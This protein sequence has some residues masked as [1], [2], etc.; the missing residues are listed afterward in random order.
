MVAAGMGR[1][2]KRP[3]RTDRESVKDSLMHEA[4]LARFTQHADLRVILLKIGAA[5][6]PVAGDE[7]RNT[8]IGPIRSPGV[9]TDAG[10]AVLE[11]DLELVP[12]RL[13]LPR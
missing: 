1:S 4:V 3:L 8:E 5:Q 9:V 2:R 11:A 12:A 13:Q 10:A 7:S 6:S